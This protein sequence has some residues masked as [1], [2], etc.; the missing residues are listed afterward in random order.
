[1]K[2]S[3]AWT[4]AI[5]LV[6]A[7]AATAYATFVD[8]STVS[9]ADRSERSSDVF[10]SFRVDDVSR[11][12]LVTGGEKFVLERGKRAA[13]AASGGATDAE[14]MVVQPLR[15]RADPGAVDV[16]LRELELAKKLREVPEAHA[17]GLG[18]PRVR[19][20]LTVGPL[21]YE[22]ALCG[23]APRP[24]GAAYL[25]LAGE[26]V[27]VV[28]RALK[29]QLMRGLDSYRDR[30]LVPYSAN[31]IARLEVDAPTGR[32]FVL[33]RKGH[34]YR[35]G[36]HTGVRAARAAVEKV[37]GAL[38]DLRAESFVDD[39]ADVAV[40]PPTMTLRLTPRDARLPPV[41]LRMGAACPS[42]GRDM[43][44][45]REAPARVS[46]CVPRSA[47]DIL[48]AAGDSLADRGLFYARADEVEAL[49]I[50][51]T[52]TPARLE[53]ARRAS[54]WHEQAPDDRQLSGAQSEAANAW[55]DDIAAAQGTDVR[56]P[57]APE[58]FAVRGRVSIVQ[59]ETGDHEVVEVG[60]PSPAG[61]LVRR[62][63]D[64][65]RLQ[66]T[67]DDARRLLPSPIA[68]EARETWPA[69]F[70]PGA[71]VSIESTC[72]QEPQR[73]KLQGGRWTLGA[74]AGFAADANTASELA[75]AFAHARA[76]AWIADDDD[77][78]FGFREASGCAVELGLAQSAA[79]VGIVFGRETT[80]GFYAH[81]LD[82]HAV[83]VASAALRA[84]A[85]HPAIDRSAIRVEATSRVTVT[86]GADQREI[87]PSDSG[88][89][90]LEEALN[91]LVATAADHV[92][93]AAAGE[94]FDRPT[95]EI[96]SAADRSTGKPSRDV[97]IGAMTRSGARD[98]YYARA[99][100][101][102]ATFVVPRKAVEAILNA[103]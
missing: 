81:V 44:V 50:E 58:P 39:A 66:L 61:V 37:F 35:I 72:G 55:V 49:R 71:V 47:G 9:D 82:A 38:G 79:R 90:K 36:G 76:E 13:P 83:F 52:A 56:V 74:P 4:P 22:F 15:Q 3:A 73:L 2:A 77:G 48:L 26:G 41:I 34:A 84:I 17:A 27:F 102:D 6:L 103:L 69:P 91:A 43:V 92:G 32:G 96:A 14:W 101:V 33:A 46:A 19:G 70:D 18:A 62:L 88:N 95:L 20:K 7:G 100:G 28:G 78:T 89:V 21:Q 5:L 23:D 67:A 86:R 63:D 25:R 51:S 99:R 1:M 54:G 30:T 8:R 11:I 53:I 80:R 64:G 16:L 87:D 85:S 75:S 60:A 29:V 24:E 68:F 10:P 94:G 98:V 65:A 12:E 40:A 59:T 45:V 42:E 31:E 57:A 93:P 97:T